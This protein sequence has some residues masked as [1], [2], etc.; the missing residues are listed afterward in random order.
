[1]A[2]EEKQLVPRALLLQCGVL[3]VQLGGDGDGRVTLDGR[4]LPLKS[5]RICWYRGQPPLITLVP[6][7]NAEFY[8]APPLPAKRTKRAKDA[9]PH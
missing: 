7:T 3:Q 4:A 1:M 2:N 5:I 8:G 9:L 6:E